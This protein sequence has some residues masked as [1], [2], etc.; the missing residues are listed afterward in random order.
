MLKKILLTLGLVAAIAFA[1]DSLKVES[2]AGQTGASS[3]EM[4]LKQEIAIRDS[5]M[6]VQNESCAAEKDSLNKKLEIE[7]AKGENW[8][9][10]YETVK[11]ANAVCAQA[12][13]VSLGVNEKKKEKEKEDKLAASTMSASAF[14]GGV[15]IGMLLFWLIFE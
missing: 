2:V 15:G 14:L 7:R 1:Q 4:E 5:V 13:S 11:E 10:S 8:E 3:V 12:V 9:K 6:A